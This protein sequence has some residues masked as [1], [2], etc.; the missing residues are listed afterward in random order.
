MSE[1]IVKSVE[2]ADIAIDQS[3]CSS[4]ATMRVQFAFTDRDTDVHSCLVEVQAR[5]AQ[6]VPDERYAVRSRNIALRKV[7]N[8]LGGKDPQTPNVFLN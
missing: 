8:Y 1:I 3:A 2:V 4:Q 5:F 6:P 7:N